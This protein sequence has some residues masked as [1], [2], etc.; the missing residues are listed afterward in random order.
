M[1]SKH[2]LKV[3]IGFCGMI[4]LGLATLVIIDSFK[5][6]KINED[7]NISPVN[8]ENS[9]QTPTKVQPSSKKSIPTKQL[10]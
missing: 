2:L 9:K 7:A 8:V 3:I 4:I 1:F 10:Q 6:K 5:D